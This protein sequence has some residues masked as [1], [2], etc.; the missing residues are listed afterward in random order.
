MSREELEEQIKNMQGNEQSLNDEQ[1]DEKPI[2][3][4]GSSGSDFKYNYEDALKNAGIDPSDVYDPMGILGKKDDNKDA[5][6]ELTYT[7]GGADGQSSDDN[8]ITTY[9]IIKR[10]TR[11]EPIPDPKKEQNRMPVT[12]GLQIFRKVLNDAE[13]PEIENKHTLTSNPLVTVAPSG[14]MVA[15]A[16]FLSTYNPI[17]AIGGGVAGAIAGPFVTKVVDA[18]TKRKKI[19]R[20][21]EDVISKLPDNEL[22][23]MISYLTEE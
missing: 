18:I 22:Q 3:E 4:F 10:K 20:Q 15:S 12:S 23:L 14:L 6:Y 11:E 8:P 9:R 19:T 2:A 16:V 5:Q 17:L 21:I 7:Y 13:M 1:S